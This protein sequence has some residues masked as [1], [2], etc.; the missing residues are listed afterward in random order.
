MQP[1]RLSLTAFCSSI[2]IFSLTPWEKKVQ[3][4]LHLSAAHSHSVATAVQNLLAPSS[5]ILPKPVGIK[6]VRVPSGGD[7]CSAAIQENRPD[8]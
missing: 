3:A 5:S 6:L 8:N 7:Y 2:V 4:L 1:L